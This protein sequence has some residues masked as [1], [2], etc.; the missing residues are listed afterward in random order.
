MQRL[1]KWLQH[2]DRLLIRMQIWKDDHG[3]DLIEF[4]LVAGFVAVSASAVMPRIDKDVTKIL[5][6]IKS[7]MKVAKTE[8]G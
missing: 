5:S 6:Q 7:I 2:W 8:G 3:Q 1:H 4:V